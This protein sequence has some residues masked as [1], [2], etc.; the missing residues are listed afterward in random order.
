[1]A[2]LDR[3]QVVLLPRREVL[4]SDLQLP[5]AV[6]YLAGYCEVMPPGRQEAVIAPMPQKGTSAASA[7]SLR[8]P[9]Q[10][11]KGERPAS[12]VRSA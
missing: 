9:G 8:R 1:M 5:E 6:A 11:A 12:V 7:R 4:V 3:F 2:S 10:A